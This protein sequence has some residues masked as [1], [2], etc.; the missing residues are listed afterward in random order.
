MTYTKLYIF[1]VYNLMSLETSIHL[2]NHYHNLCHKHIHPP[3]RLP[4]ALFS[5]CYYYYYFVIRTQ[6][7]RTGLW[8]PEGKEA[9]WRWGGRGEGRHVPVVGGT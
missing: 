5:Y 6:L 1:N 7:K 2:Q 3:Q 4:P 9:W 8:L